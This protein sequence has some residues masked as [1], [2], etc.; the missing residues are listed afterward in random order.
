M[1][2]STMADKSFGPCWPI[3]NPNIVTLVRDD[4][5][6]IGVHHDLIDLASML[7]DL[8]EMMGYD[9]LPGQTWGFAFRAIA[10]TQ[11][12]SNHSTGTAFDINAPSNPQSYTLKTN[13]PTDVIAMWKAHGFR[14]GGDYQPPTKFDTMHFEFMGTVTE[15]HAYADSLRGF[16][17]HHGSPAP[18]APALTQ[19]EMTMFLA[20]CPDNKQW[21]ISDGIHRWD[22]ID[23]NHLVDMQNLL[24]TKTINL[25]T[26]N[27][28]INLTGK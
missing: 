11:R 13:L 26:Y 17:A 23:G 7:M 20:Y 24:P 10:G 12:P 9:I 22:V 5:L 15:A 19:G 18:T 1:W 8:T 16:L 14:W 25:R 2:V 21:K 28:L 3:H 27:R 6:R 4:G